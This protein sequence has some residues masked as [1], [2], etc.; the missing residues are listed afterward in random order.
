MQRGG[1]YS[2]VHCRRPQ[3]GK[4]IV[5]GKEFIATVAGQGDRDR[6]A[7]ETTQHVSGKQRSVAKG[8]IYTAQHLWNKRF[9]PLPDRVSSRD[10]SFQNGPQPRLRNRIH[11]KLG[12]RKPIVKVIDLPSAAVGTQ[13]CEHGAGVE[14]SAKKHAYRNVADHSAYSCLLQQ[15]RQLI[16]QFSLGPVAQPPR[17]HQSRTPICCDR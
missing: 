6:L 3:R 9:S 5:A 15:V 1:H 14:T 4:R 13:A 11:S 10:V 16:D 17:L 7:C 12:S 8:L 2:I